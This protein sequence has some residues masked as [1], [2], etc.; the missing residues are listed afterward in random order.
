MAQNNQNWD[1]LGRNIQDIVD[2]AVNSRDFQKLEQT[3]RQVVEKAVDMG[4][5]TVRRVVE[6][7]A[8]RDVKKLYGNTGALTVKGGLKACGGGILSLTTFSFV[9]ATL[10]ANLM[11]LGNLILAAASLACF[12]GSLWLTYSGVSLLGMVK[13]FKIYRRVLGNKTHCAIESLA[14]SAGKSVSF[15]RREL[16]RMIDQGLFLEGNLDKEENRLITSRETYHH[17]EQ[18][19]LAYEERKRQ[20]IAAEAQKASVDPKLQEILNKGDAFVAQIRACNDAIPGEEIST[21]ISHMEMI[22]ERIFDRAEADPDVVPDLKKLMDYYLP[23]TVKLLNAYADM[24]AQPVQGE[25]I[26]ASKR[27]IESTLDTLNL[28]FEKLLDSI[29]KETSLD[30]SSDIS[31]LNVL[32]AQEGLTDDEFSKIKKQ[33]NL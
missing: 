31:T 3:V 16:W 18:S 21:K 17:Y 8:A 10:S 27:E 24:D 5:T 7:P 23:M 13:R 4:G 14:R 26:Q 28:A 6:K 19:R 25:T 20:Q 11:N 33:Q 1:D 15:V 29:F 22:I 12:G 9:A 30:I 2:R 32:L